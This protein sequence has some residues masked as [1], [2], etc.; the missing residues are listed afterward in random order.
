MRCV[1]VFMLALLLT[2]A[3]ETAAREEEQRPG[4][5]DFSGEW[6]LNPEKSGVEEDGRG[7]RRQA[8]PPLMSVEQSDK[9][10]VVTRVRKNRE[11][12]EVKTALT[13][14]L[15]GKKTKNKTEMGR[16]ESTAGWLEGGRVLELV[17]LSEVEREG[18]KFT[19]E[20]V[21]TWS[22]ADEI[23]TIETVRHTP[24]G[25]MRSTAVYERPAPGR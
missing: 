17:S 16:L 7:R 10:L 20:T 4:K 5:P 3:V 9:K 13:Y 11:G 18:M 1:T 24:R 14:S 19:V 25:E 21:Q 8:Q 12:K 22:L 6:V 2:G 23:L 15:E